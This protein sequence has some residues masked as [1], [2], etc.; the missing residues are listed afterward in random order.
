MRAAGSPVT[1]AST[2]PL[3]RDC[4]SMTWLPIWSLAELPIWPPV[5]SLAP[6]VAC[7]FAR[8]FIWPSTC[9]F[10]ISSPFARRFVHSFCRCPV[11]SSICHFVRHDAAQPRDARRQESLGHMPEAHFSV[12]ILSRARS[13][14]RN[15][16]Q[17]TCLCPTASQSATGRTRLPPARRPTRFPTYPRAN[18]QRYIAI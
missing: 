6:S 10:A 4:C 11:R 9:S 18:P 5:R 1:S 17:P 15:P 16:T 2:S 3:N 12:A 8:S 14:S 13:A 7:P